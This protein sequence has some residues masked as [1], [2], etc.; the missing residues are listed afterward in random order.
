MT[1]PAQLAD[2]DQAIAQFRVDIS[3]LADQARGLTAVRGRELA[4][5]DIVKHLFTEH[6]D[7]VRCIAGVALMMLVHGESG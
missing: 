3:V 5:A 4:T 1:N 2:I 7:K 6:P